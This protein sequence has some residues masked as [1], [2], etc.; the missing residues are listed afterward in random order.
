VEDVLSITPSMPNA[1]HD[2]M[3]PLMRRASGTHMP[4]VCAY[5]MRQ[6]EAVLTLPHEALKRVLTSDW[7]EKPF[8]LPRDTDACPRRFDDLWRHEGVIGF[9]D[10]RDGLGEL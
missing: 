9:R 8:P 7:Q 3:A 5:A 2:I 6:L 1:P 4:I 10:G